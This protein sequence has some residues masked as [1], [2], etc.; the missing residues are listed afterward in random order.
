[1]TSSIRRVDNGW[2]VMT[3]D[4]PFTNEYICNEWDD[5]LCLLRDKHF[6][7]NGSPMR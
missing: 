5:V 2:I 6:K 4:G 1:M 7:A 3:K